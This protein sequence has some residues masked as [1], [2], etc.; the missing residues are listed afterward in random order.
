MA[1]FPINGLTNEDIIKKKQIA[2]PKM[3]IGNLW[4]EVRR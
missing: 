4:F 3:F 2:I 1:A